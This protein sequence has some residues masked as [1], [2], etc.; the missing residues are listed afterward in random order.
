MQDD[1]TLRSSL[2]TRINVVLVNT[3]EAEKRLGTARTE[4]E[5]CET[6]ANAELEQAT[7]AAKVEFETRTA[8]ARAAYNKTV[9]AAKS[10]LGTSTAE[11]KKLREEYG[12]L[13]KRL[14]DSLPEVEQ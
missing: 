8:E 4:L 14:A 6:L 12:S 2:I 10:E 11:L 3:E 7:C 9:N 5:R 13:R 1:V